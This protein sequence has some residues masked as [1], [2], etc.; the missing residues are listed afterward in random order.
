[1]NRVADRNAAVEEHVEGDRRRQLG[2]ERRQDAF[3]R[4]DRFDGVGAGLPLDGQDDR[5]LVDVPTGQTDV[6]DAIDRIGDVFEPH[7]RTIAPSDDQRTEFRGGGQLAVSLDGEGLPPPVE[8]A[9]RLIDVVLRQ[10]LLQ[11]VETDTPA[12][13]LVRIG[14]DAH[15]VFLRTEN[16]HLRDAGNRR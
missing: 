13:E 12:G 7:R 9:N 5:P 16:L 3:D 14:L 6:L 1:M 10:R 11:F 15:R 2:L 4:I 8:L